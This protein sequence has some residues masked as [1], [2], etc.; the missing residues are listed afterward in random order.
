MDITQ[1]FT[2]ILHQGAQTLLVPVV[3]ALIVLV[4]I[5]AFSIGMV[6]AEF[7]TERRHYK[8]DH[9]RIIADIR[10][11]SP[12]EL[13]D[14]IAHAG[15][16]RKQVRALTNVA[17]NMGL[18]DDELFALA[19]VELERIDAVYTHRVN[20]TDTISKVAPML[21]LMGTL[22]P[23][24]PGI[25][26][27]GQADVSILSS[28][29]LVAFDTTIAGLVAAVVALV[30]SRVRKT[31]YGQYHI[32]MQ[33]LMSCILE[34]A[35]IARE[36]G[37][38]LPYGKGRDADGVEDRKTESSAREAQMPVDSRTSAIE[39]GLSAAEGEA[40]QQMQVVQ[41]APQL[42]QIMEEAL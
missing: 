11:S 40:A 16:L 31:W 35:A 5:T 9:K 28:S 20:I 42:Q 2:L 32:M 7:F 4:L 27:M 8:A 17:D 12:E 24:G 15:L 38:Q 39:S 22:I 19:E 1:A 34:E 21:G 14:I 26:A 29:L 10:D 30:I 36:S 18:P 6:V 33:S 13:P 25:V 23:L 41:I 3:V 37:I